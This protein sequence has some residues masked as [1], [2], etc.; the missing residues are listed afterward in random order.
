MPD[1]REKRVETVSAVDDDR[2]VDEIKAFHE[3]VSD[4]RWRLVCVTAGS[5]YRTAWL[6]F[7]PS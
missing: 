6:E 5:G 2:L 3:R 7:D 1:K 4:L